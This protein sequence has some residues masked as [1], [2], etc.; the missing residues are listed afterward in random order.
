METSFLAHRSGGIY[1]PSTLED[2]WYEDREQDV[3]GDVG[4]SMIGR[5]STRGFAR[6][7]LENHLTLAPRQNRRMDLLCMRRC[8]GDGDKGFHQTTS[9]TD[10]PNP[11]KTCLREKRS[12]VRIDSFKHT[13]NP[14]PT[15]KPQH[16]V[17]MWS[18]LPRHP[19]TYG[20]RSFETTTQSAYDNGLTSKTDPLMPTLPL[21]CR[22]GHEKA[23]TNF[24][25]FPS[26]VSRYIP[27][28]YTHLTLPTKRIV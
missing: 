28:S 19:H 15:E 22:G 23:K 8:L 9:R 26:G 27:V 14:R 18:S 24:N 2:N 20:R 1:G 4:G 5:T 6:R 17:T 7:G 25:V 10:Y 12:L 11:S 13:L 3:V 16:E 21:E